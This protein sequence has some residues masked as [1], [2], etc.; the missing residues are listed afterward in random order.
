MHWDPWSDESMP[1][2]CMP[3]IVDYYINN[4][5]AVLLDF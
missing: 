2:S 5:L 3:A 1:P 4:D